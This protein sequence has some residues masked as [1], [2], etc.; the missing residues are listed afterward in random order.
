MTDVNN[1]P[2]PVTIR[3]R[4]IPHFNRIVEILKYSYGYIDISTMEGL[5]E[6]II[7]LVMVFQIILFALTQKKTMY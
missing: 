3:S 7:L 6:A 4:Q 5:G 1:G 2:I